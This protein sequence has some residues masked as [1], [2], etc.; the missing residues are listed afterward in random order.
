MN[1]DRLR[2]FVNERPVDVA[3][4][5]TVGAAVAALDPGLGALLT[6]ETAYVTDATGRTVDASDPVREAGAVFRVVVRAR[7]AE[8][9]LT[10]ASLRSW[11]KVELHVHLDGSLRPETMLELAREQ[12][13]H[14][15]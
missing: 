4:G 12:H 3:R 7:R 8:G 11:P 5:A 15:P 1:M 14:L 9:T 6:E 2:I 13:I 10:K